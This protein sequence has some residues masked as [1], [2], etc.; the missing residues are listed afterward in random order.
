MSQSLPAKCTGRIALVRGVSAAST[1]AGSRQRV[2]GSQSA[3]TGVAPVCR[4][5]FT[6][7]QKVSG[8]VTTS[9]PGPIPLAIMARWSA[10]V[11]DATATACSAPV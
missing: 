11:H 8:V 1:R 4:I 10:A 3:S 2:R 6:V 5:A 9:S 7:A